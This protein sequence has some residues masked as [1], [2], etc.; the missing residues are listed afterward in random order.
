KTNGTEYTA[1]I[2][3]NALTAF[4][5]VA[6]VDEGT[7]FVSEAVYSLVGVPQVTPESGRATYD[8]LVVITLGEGVP[9][10]GVKIYYTTDGTEPSAT[11]GTEYTAPFKL[12]APM[13]KVIAVKGEDVSPVV[14]RE[15]SL[16]PAAP[17]PTPGAGKVPYG[18]KVKLTCATDNAEIYYRIDGGYTPLSKSDKRYEEGEEIEI[19][20]TC[21]LKV[22]AFVGDAASVQSTYRYT[23]TLA[24]PEFSVPEGEVQAGTRVVL[25][26]KS[27]EANT[28]RDKQI[29]IAYT[30]DG[31]D[32]DRNSTLYTEPIEL[33]EDVTIKAIT[34][35]VWTQGFEKSGISTATYTVKETPAE[36]VAK[37]EFSIAS[38]EVS[39]GAKVEISCATEGAKIYYYCYIGDAEPKAIEYKE[40]IE[41]TQSMKISAVAMMGD[42][43]S[44]VAEAT[45]TVIAKPTFSIAAGEVEA[46]TT[47]TLACATEEAVIYYTV[48]GSE[49]TAES[50]EYK[51]AIEITKAMTVKAIAIKGEAK[52]EVAEA[53]YTIKTA[54]EDVELAGV[55]VYPNPSNGVFNIELPVAATIEVFMSNGMLYQRVKALAGSATLNIERSGIYF[56][57]I[58]GEGRTAIKRVVVR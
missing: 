9:T 4:K 56:F 28:I 23:V 17:V 38:G 33:T 43:K 21:Q 29:N 25:S 11:N 36:K 27:I 3:I 31:S 6:V 55:S 15:Y 12:R 13:L 32:P 51:D 19:T 47:V 41:I 48:D 20:T 39:F 54:N 46:G 37:P 45:Y 16:L 1:P 52:S 24:D 7:S 10:E 42:D 22:I 5:A 40:A 57:R 58:T 26:S 18:T 2:T 35:T 34:W 30:T 14:T 49:P 50:T 8:S 44:E 53:A